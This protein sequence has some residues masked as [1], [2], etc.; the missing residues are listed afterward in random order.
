MS[1][2]HRLH[3]RANSQPRSKFRDLIDTLRTRVSLKEQ[4]SP[5]HLPIHSQQSLPQ[6]PNDILPVTQLPRPQVVQASNRAVEEGDGSEEEID[7]SEIEETL[8]ETEQESTREAE[9]ERVL[10]NEITDLLRPEQRMAAPKNEGR[11]GCIRR[12]RFTLNKPTIKQ[13]KYTKMPRPQPYI[14]AESPN[15]V[16]R[17]AIKE[18]DEMEMIKFWNSTAKID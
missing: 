17:T 15:L 2:P 5:A 18:A 3:L 8:S 1:T 7:L 4:I 12:Q 11:T 6:P 16:L 13:P 14:P 10:V 9:G